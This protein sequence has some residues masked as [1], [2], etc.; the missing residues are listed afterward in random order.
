MTDFELTFYFGGAAF[1]LIVRAV[2][3]DDAKELGQ[4]LFPTASFIAV[5]EIQG[6]TP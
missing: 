4:A 3:E 6:E 1:D 5:N 2:D